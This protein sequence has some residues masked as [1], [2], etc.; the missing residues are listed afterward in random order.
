MDV[1]VTLSRLYRVLV[2]FR[3]STDTLCKNFT[4]FPISTYVPLALNIL[5]NHTYGVVSGAKQSLPLQLGCE[6]VQY[7]SL[8]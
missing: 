6:R 3:M 5:C 7:S 2:N 1:G 8:N 4:S